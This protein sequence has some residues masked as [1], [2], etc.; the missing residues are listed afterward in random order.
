MN[1]GDE[2]TALPDTPTNGVHK[3][4]LEDLDI[5]TGL[6]NFQTLFNK[7]EEVDEE[8]DAEAMLKI[9]IEKGELEEREKALEIV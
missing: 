4:F 6:V 2:M 7:D 8:E 5:V 9:Q 1:D 3:E